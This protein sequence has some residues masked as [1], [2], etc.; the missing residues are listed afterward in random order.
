MNQLTTGEAISLMRKRHKLSQSEL[1]KRAGVHRN[2]ISQLER[3]NLNVTL[4]TIGKIAE[5]LGYQVEYVLKEKHDR[6][7]PL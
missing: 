7:D 2:T 3:G 5:A 4:D 1:A 6:P